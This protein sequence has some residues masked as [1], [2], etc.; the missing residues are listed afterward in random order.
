MMLRLLTMN[1]THRTRTTGARSALPNSL[2]KPGA[3]S[4]KKP[5]KN[6][7]SRSEDVN[8]ARTLPG[9]MVRSWMRAEPTPIWPK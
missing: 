7:P 9:E 4:Q 3:A 5:K 2:P 1:V 8:A 6:A